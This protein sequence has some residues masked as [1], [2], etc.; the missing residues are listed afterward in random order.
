MKIYYGNK[1]SKIIRV[2][3]KTPF[4]PL[5]LVRVE[6]SLKPINDGI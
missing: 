1:F 6:V 4:K 3:E 2:Y 5:N